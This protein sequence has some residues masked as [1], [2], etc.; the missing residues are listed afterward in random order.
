MDWS[1]SVVLLLSVLAL[2]PIIQPRVGRVV[3]T[4]RGMFFVFLDL[5][6]HDH[7]Q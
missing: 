3:L 1:M 5:V 6:D 2:P 4:K 7:T